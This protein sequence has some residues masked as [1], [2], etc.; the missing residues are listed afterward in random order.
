MNAKK[1]IFVKNEQD[2]DNAIPTILS[3]IDSHR[4]VLLKGNLGA[5][6]TTFVRH[7]MR[8]FGVTTEIV[9]PTFTI[10]N[11]YDLPEG[12]KNCSRVYHMDLYRL[13]TEF[14][15]EEAGIFDMIYSTDFCLIEWPEIVLPFIDEPCILLEIEILENGRNV[16]CLAID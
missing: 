5:G 3:W 2:W 4:I 13:K 10:V 7:L 8:S 16:V 9:S 15:L 11:P 6:K 1:E 12:Q 14:E